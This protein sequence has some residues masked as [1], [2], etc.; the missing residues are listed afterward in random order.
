VKIFQTIKSVEL[1]LILS[2]FL[3]RIRVP[4]KCKGLEISSMEMMMMEVQMAH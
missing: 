2:N 1:A 3:A 4:G